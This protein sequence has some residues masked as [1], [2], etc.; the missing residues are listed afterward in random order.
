MEEEPAQSVTLGTNRSEDTMSVGFQSNLLV[1]ARFLELCNRQRENRFVMRARVAQEEGSEPELA[2]NY[3][4]PNAT[5]T[6]GTIRFCRGKPL[7]A[8]LAGWAVESGLGIRP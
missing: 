3:A 5:K 6:E 8:I 1:R 4:D 7:I 2:E